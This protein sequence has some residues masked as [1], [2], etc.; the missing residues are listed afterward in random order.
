M[1][2]SYLNHSPE[3]D[4]Y[5]VRWSSPD[6]DVLIEVKR[7]TNVS[8]L[9]DGLVALSYALAQDRSQR[10]ARGLCVLTKTRLSEQRLRDELAR[11][12]CV[13]RPDLSSLIFLAAVAD[14]GRIVG[15]LPPAPGENLER[16]ILDLAHDESSGGRVSR[17]SVKAF[18]VHSWL[19]GQGPQSMAALKRATGASYPTVA[20]T[21]ADLRGLGVLAESPAG[22]M[23]H[24]PSWEAWRHLAERQIA[25]RK[26]LRFVDPSGH[27][28]P[29]EQLVR[30]L[31]GV[32]EKN[33]GTKV[34]IGG[35]LGAFDY[36]PEL[37]ISAAPRLDLSVY[38][39]DTRF[40]RKLDAALVQTADPTAKAAVVLH[41]HR[42]LKSAPDR[43]QPGRRAA[44]ALDCLADLLELGYQAE[45][46]DFTSALAR[47][48]RSSTHKS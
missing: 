14:R 42:G 13:I 21:L 33:P 17:Q 12:R 35:V 39:N 16:V 1:D 31:Q 44:S 37:D 15:D 24:E 36:D 4:L 29:P 19:V 38:D 40:M 30:R 46:R 10:R 32:F 41:L 5:D 3:G 20:A 9:R 22:A 27:A 34:A 18:L 11:F 2:S 23:L 28:R 47:L 43:D 48:A 26:I 45:A 25:D 7:T 6:G 8:D